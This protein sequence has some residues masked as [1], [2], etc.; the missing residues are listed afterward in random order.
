MRW[1]VVGYQDEHPV[2]TSEIPYERPHGLRFT[3]LDDFGTVERRPSRGREWHRVHSPCL[4]AFWAFSEAG[5]PFSWVDRCRKVLPQTEVRFSH[6]DLLLTSLQS[7]SSWERV[8]QSALNILTAIY[9]VS[10]HQKQEASETFH[11]P[12]AIRQNQT[13]IAGLSARRGSIVWR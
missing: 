11:G 2:E 7:V 13:V 3:S 1:I 4:L 8:V 12:S 9:T 6:F 10:E 5:E